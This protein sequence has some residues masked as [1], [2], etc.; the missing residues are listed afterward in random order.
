MKVLLRRRLFGFMALGF[1]FL[2]FGMKGSGFGQ[3]FRGAQLR[4]YFFPPT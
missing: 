1:R 4:F 3:G 2:G